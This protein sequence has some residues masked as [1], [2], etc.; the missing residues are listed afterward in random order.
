MTTSNLSLGVPYCRRSAILP[1]EANLGFFFVRGLG[2]GSTSVCAGPLDI[3]RGGVG[4]GRARRREGGLGRSGV[5][6]G[7]AGCEDGG[8]GK[9]EMGLTLGVEACAVGRDG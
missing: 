2:E 1:K 4:L 9:R 6:A 8:V 5:E 3:R 7:S